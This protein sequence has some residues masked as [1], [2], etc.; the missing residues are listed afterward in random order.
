[1]PNK[2]QR[3]R[4]RRKAQQDHSKNKRIK[5][6]KP[7]WIQQ[8][9]KLQ[10]LAADEQPDDSSSKE[11]FEVNIILSTVYLTDDYRTIPSDTKSEKVE[12]AAL[13]EAETK[14]IEKE[15]EDAP[16]PRSLANYPKVELPTTIPSPPVSNDDSPAAKDEDEFTKKMNEDEVISSSIV[17]N[18]NEASAVA[19]EKQAGSVPDAEKKSDAVPLIESSIITDA[20]PNDH[21]LEPRIRITPHP[22]CLVKEIPGKPPIFFKDLPN[23]DCG[24]GK[25]NPHDK[26]IVADKYWAQRRRLFTKFDHGIQLDKEGWF[27]VTPE[28]IANHIA[29]RFVTKLPAVGEAESTS[30]VILD[31]FVG[32]G[33][34]AIALALRPEVSK[35]VCVDTSQ[36]RLSMAAT[37]AHI[38]GIA[39]SKMIFIHGDACDVLRHYQGG[40]RSDRDGNSSSAKDDQARQPKGACNYPIGGVELLPDHLDGVFLSPPWG[41]SN[42]EGVGPSHYDL[43]CIQL[44]NGMDGNQL[45]ELAAKASGG[46]LAYFLPR[47]I[48]GFLLAQAAYG[49]SARLTRLELEQNYLNR[50]LKTVTLYAL[51]SVQE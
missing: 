2:K 46:L 37:N 18:G 30:L 15:A 20:P 38:Y 22:S 42:Y 9:V 49:S 23:G 31:A 45:L 28:A 43:S 14:T 17:A 7:F 34:N 12:A 25:V 50:K 21:I 19:R 33:G 26:A 32:V 39:S 47:N 36:E 48:N 16:E 1:M 44:S 8:Q 27:S 10:Q 3:Q 41:G 35:V 5:R 51:D 24:D 11:D 13:A 40:K 6:N 29:K 4:K